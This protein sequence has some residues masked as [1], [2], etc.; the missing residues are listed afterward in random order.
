MTAGVGT[1]S[2]RR[3]SR[4]SL[5]VVGGSYAAVQVAASAREAGYDGRITLITDESHLPYHKPPLSKGFLVG[6]ATDDDLW[7]RGEGFFGANEV[8]FLAGR[9]VRSIDRGARRLELDVCERPIPFDDLV[10]ACG[11]RARPLPVPGAGLDG[12]VSLRSLDDAKALK[13]RIDAAQAV[14]VVGGGF[15][16]L[17]TASAAVALGKEVTVVEAGPNLLGRAVSGQVSSFLKTVHQSRG[18]G[19]RLATSLSE[20]Q[21]S[22]GRVIAAVCGDG[23]VLPCDLAIVGVGALPNVELGAAAGLDADNGIVVDEHGR[24][25]ADPRVFAAG[26]CSNHPSRFTGARLRLESVQNALDQARAVGAAVAGRDEPHASVPRFWSDQYDIKLQMVG[27]SSGCDAR[28]V[29]GSVDEGRFSVFFFRDG[30]LRAID[31]V[32]R[33]GDQII[34]RRILA[35]GGSPSLEEAADLSFDLRRCLP[36]SHQAA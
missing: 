31:S 1:P 24:T 8:E 30:R 29:R 6:K 12:I 35:G 36:D 26:D 21:G 2:G 18:V 4:P 5:V 28:A 27:L 19:L 23:A 17:E 10:L 15:I 14:V 3:T 22:G 34:G 16:G 32:N 7:L 13:E 20:F 25:G 33:P 9:R 11:A